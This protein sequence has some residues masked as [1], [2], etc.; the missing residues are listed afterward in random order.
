MDSQVE[1]QIRSDYHEN[2][3]A[4]VKGVF[5]AAEIAE[6]A[7]ECDRLKAEGLKHPKTFRHQNILYVI[8]Q[9][10]EVGRILQFMQWP[11]YISAV[12]QKYRVDSR[13]LSIVEPLIGNNLKQIINQV[14][15]KPAG[16]KQTGFAY[17]Q[18]CRFRRPANAYRELDTSY[19]QTAIAI[20]SHRSE[21]GCMKVYP[22]SHR[23]GDLKLN[24]ERGVMEAQFDDRS[25]IERGLHPS[26]LV[27]LIL[28]PGDVALW[29]PYL[30]HG[31]GS[32]HSSMDRR[33]Y[34]NGYVMADNCD[35]GEWAFR[36][37]KP[38]RLG[39][40]VLVQYEDLFSRPEPHYV[41]GSAHAYRD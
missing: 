25:L 41:E 14:I 5:L 27:D 11:A 35:R 19:V 6:I 8:R 13:L 37:G 33:F 38:C 4:I 9:D 32:N 30:I 3:Y 26:K 1:S 40:P 18:D 23:L 21:N 22:G 20:D 34:V 31:S 16:A 29:G 39:D 7:Q 2:G 17:H 15:W 36:N 28:D 24:V 10:G 12:L